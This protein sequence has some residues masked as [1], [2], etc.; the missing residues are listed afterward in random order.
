M[1]QLKALAVVAAGSLVALGLAGCDQ[2]DRAATENKAEQKTSAAENK[3]EKKADELGDKVD[4]K[5]DQAKNDVKND[6][7]NMAPKAT[8]GGPAVAGTREWARDKMAQVR[9]DHYMTCGDIA[10][11]KKYDTMDSCVTRERASLDK[12]WELKDCAKVDEPRL[13]A[14]ITAVKAKK[15]DTLFNTTPSECNESKV[16]IKP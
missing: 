15:C 4:N 10:K 6:I 7:N 16:C 14:C 1:I 13:D 2:N 12:D 8:G 5:A 3:T 9:C 11:D